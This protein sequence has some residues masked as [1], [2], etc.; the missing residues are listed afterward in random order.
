MD[1]HGLKKPDVFVALIIG[2]TLT[3]GVVGFLW[4]WPLVIPFLAIFRF[5]RWSLTTI[6]ASIPVFV[7]GHWVARRILAYQAHD[8][9]TWSILIDWVTGWAMMILLGIILLGL[10]LYSVWVWILLA[11]GLNLA[12]LV[13]LIRRRWQPIVTFWR[14]ILPVLQED[15]VGETTGSAKVWNECILFIVFLAFLQA[16]IPPNTRDELAYHL[17]MPKLW[18]IQHNWWMNTDNYHLV[19]PANIEIVWGYALAVGG[20]HIPRLITLMFGVMTIGGMRRWLKEQHFDSW[21]CGISLFFFLITPL[22][23]VMLSINY[24]E[25][26]LFLFIFLGWWTSQQYIKT[27]KRVYASLTAITWGISLGTKYSTLPVIC[28]LGF[29]WMVAIFHHLTGRHALIALLILLIGGF[30][31]SGPWFMRNYWLTGDPIY[32]LGNLFPFQESRMAAYSS[33]RVSDLTHYAKLTGFWRWNPWLYHTTIDRRS[34]QRMHPGWLFLQGIV[35][36]FGWK[37]RRNRPWFTVVTLSL[38]FFYFTPSP[39]IYFPLM[40]LTWS[41][42]PAYLRTLAQ[43]RRLRLMVSGLM[44]LFA[45]PSLSLTIH[46]WFMTYNRASQDYLIGLMDDRGLLRKDKLLT[47]VMEWVR[48]ETPLDSHVWVW[49]DDQVL[50]FDRWVRPSSPYDP[51]AFLTI[52]STSGTQELL[53]EIKKD[54]IEYIVVNTAKCPLPLKSVNTETISLTIPDHLQEQLHLWMNRYLTVLFRDQQ[55]VLYK[56]L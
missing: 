23:M 20:L 53:H 3:M 39:R 19:F 50:Y 41:F 38:L 33:P 17:V 51:P 7:L 37:F 47:P 40:G 45:I 36:L 43:Q 6:Y 30:G 1:F 35:L 14:H 2:L 29:E 44:V 27:G 52:A 25:W 26:P 55:F 5:L 13:W 16:L 56:I 9:L 15:F 24:V 8:S 31:F 28:L 54:Q 34:D 4:K 42:L 49:C 10:G 12:I 46:F 22:T 32:P 21:T 18:E 48:K 11:L